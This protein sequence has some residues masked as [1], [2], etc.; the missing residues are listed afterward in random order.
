MQNS[1][2]TATEQLSEWKSAD[3]TSFMIFNI[4]AAACIIVNLLVCTTVL[5]CLCAR[6]N[7]RES[8]SFILLQLVLN[9]VNE[10][11]YGMNIFF[12][13]FYTNNWKGRH[14]MIH[15]GIS[16]GVLSFILS[17]WVFVY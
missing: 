8:H 14:T 5:I 4:V 7:I 1:I 2:Q 11:L 12:T 10:L 6:R 17:Q 3:Q 15:Y 13:G 9:I 16:L